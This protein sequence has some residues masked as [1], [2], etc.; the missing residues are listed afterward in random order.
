[1][2]LITIDQQHFINKEGSIIIIEDEIGDQEI[3][4]NVFR[5]LYYDNEIVFSLSRKKRWITW[6]KLLFLPC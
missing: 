6:I 5:K 1:L 2:R 3:L 4:Q